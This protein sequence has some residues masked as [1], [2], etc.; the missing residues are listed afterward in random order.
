ML[1]SFYFP[2]NSNVNKS[3]RAIRQNFKRIPGDRFIMVIG[4]IT[5]SD[6]K[7][8]EEEVNSQPVI[9]LR[10]SRRARQGLPIAKY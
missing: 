4:S 5:Y 3:S 10:D 1:D 2:T 7:Y 6:I 8:N 9:A